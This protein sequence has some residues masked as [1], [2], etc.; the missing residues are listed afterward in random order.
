MGHH[1][2]E[3][4]IGALRALLSRS[5]FDA[6]RC[7]QGLEALRHYRCHWD[8]KR[9]VPGARPV[10]DWSSHAADAARTAAM[11]L[12]LFPASRRPQPRRAESE[13]DILSR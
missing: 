3:D 7:A 5:W 1:A 8:E 2:I 10:H 4:G 9:N 6:E 11:G 12:D 13:Y